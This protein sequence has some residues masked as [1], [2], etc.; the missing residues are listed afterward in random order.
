MQTLN[1]PT[2][3]ARLSSYH[4]IICTLPIY[5]V[6]THILISLSSIL[7]EN[8]YVYIGLLSVMGGNFVRADDIEIIDYRLPSAHVYSM[9]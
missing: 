6:K 8:L 4:I 5:I 2:Y 1:K 3:F 7:S 9:V